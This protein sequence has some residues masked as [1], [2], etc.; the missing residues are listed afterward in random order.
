MNVGSLGTERFDLTPDG[1][2][3]YAWMKQQQGGAVER[4]EA[5]VRRLLDAGSFSVRHRTAYERWTGAEAT[6]GG[7]ESEA[8]FTAIGH[9]CREAVQLL[10]TDLVETHRPPDA[11]ADPQL[12]VHKLRAVVR[13]V[14]LS[15]TN[16]EFAAALLAYA[17]RREREQ[18]LWEDARRVC[19]RRPWSCSN[20]T[21]CSARDRRPQKRRKPPRT[22]SE[23]LGL[24]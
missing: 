8:A 22:D 6:L 16:S 10:V 15:K 13:Q 18:L 21:G 14:G 17:A 12:T 7:A 1:K 9:A 23:T 19:S 11:D 2:L 24:M 5:E 20:S 4:L 3:Y